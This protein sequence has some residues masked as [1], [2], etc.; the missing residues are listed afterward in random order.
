METEN[1]VRSFALS[2]EEI[3]DSLIRVFD[4][5][6][7][8]F[9]PALLKK[10][11]LLKEQVAVLQVTSSDCLLDKPSDFITILSERDSDNEVLAYSLMPHVMSI[12]LSAT[13]EPESYN[14]DK[15]TKILQ[16]LLYVTADI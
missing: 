4:Y 3:P 5:A 13:E 16:Y 1:E 10:Y 9:S 2:L 7:S 12:I 15:T 8:T 11:L 14:H 6:H